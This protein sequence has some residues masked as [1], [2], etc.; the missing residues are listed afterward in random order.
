MGEVQ[1]VALL[2]EQVGEPLPAVGRLE[3]DLQ[4]AAELGQDRLQRLRVVRDSA[5]EQLPALLV[6]GGDL[7]ALAMEIDADVDHLLGPPSVPTSTT[8]SAYRLG[9]GSASRPAPSWHQA[10]RSVV[11]YL[12]FVVCVP[13]L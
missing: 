5:R 2:G 9:R 1:L 13:P 12:G 6:E 4:L 3:R 7:R 10:P 8:P 11:S